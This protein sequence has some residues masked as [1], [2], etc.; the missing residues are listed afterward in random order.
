MQRDEQLDAPSSPFRAPSTT[1]AHK[2]AA[3]TGTPTGSVR[4][5]ISTCLLF[6]Q[7]H[8]GSAPY[9]W[10][11]GNALGADKAGLHRPVLCLHVAKS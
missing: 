5:F 10:A 2:G 1:S 6:E 3:A 7:N 11:L 9:M 4:R 8:K